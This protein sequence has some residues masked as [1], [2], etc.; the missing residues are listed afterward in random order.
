MCRFHRP[1]QGGCSLS[2]RM[3]QVAVPGVPAPR[4]GRSHAASKWRRGHRTIGI[5]NR[6]NSTASAMRATIPGC[7]YGALAEASR[8]A[9]LRKLFDIRC[10]GRNAG[11]ASRLPGV[12]TSPT[13]RT[14]IAVARASAVAATDNVM[15]ELTRESVVAAAC[16]SIARISSGSAMFVSDSQLS[17]RAP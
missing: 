13:A 12:T 9:H 1:A 2:R 4:A 17:A 16:R 15:R 7:N 11:L 3:P 8:E 10:V 6:S 14:A 5:E